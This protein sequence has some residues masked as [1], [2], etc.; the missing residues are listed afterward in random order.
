MFSG[1]HQSRVEPGQIG[2]KHSPHHLMRIFKSATSSD[3][4]TLNMFAGEHRGDVE[5]SADGFL[6]GG[7]MYR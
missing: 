7:G 3:G 1:E 2:G 6:G 5:G 4:A